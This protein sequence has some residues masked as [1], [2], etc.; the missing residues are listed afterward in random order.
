[1]TF[2]VLDVYFLLLQI[3]IFLLQPTCSWAN[4]KTLYI[5]LKL[6]INIFPLQPTYCSS[7]NGKTLF[8]FLK[9]TSPMGSSSAAITYCWSGAAFAKKTLGWN[10][11][12][13][14]SDFYQP[15]GN[16]FFLFSTNW[17]ISSYFYH[18]WNRFFIYFS[19]DIKFLHVF[20]I[21]WNVLLIFSAVILFR[22]LG[23]H[24]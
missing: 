2:N 6:Q 24:I 17:I 1:M 8:M 13:I 21:R 20:I 15:K 5:F 16:K 9:L 14:S 18:P 7:A 23:Q 3:N 11:L 22:V 4:G 10:K 19:N 12:F